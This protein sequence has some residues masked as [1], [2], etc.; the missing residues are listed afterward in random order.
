MADAEK[1]NISRLDFNINDAINSLD[2]VDK[3]LKSIAESSN[4]YAEKI[5]KN[6][7]SGITVNINSN[8]LQKNLSKVENLSKNTQEQ[9]LK[10]AQKNQYKITEITLAEEEKRKTAAYKSALAQEQYN[11]RVAKSTESLYDKITQYAKTYVIYQGFNALKQGISETIDEMVEVEQQMVAIDRV[12][13]EDSLNIDKYRDKLIQLAYDYGNSFNNVADITLRLA[14]AGFDSQE[15][16]ALTEKTLLALNT[17]ELDATQ[18]TDDMVAVMAQWGLMTGDAKEEAESY[19]SIID[20]IN[21]VADN[22][23]TTSADMMDALKK[24]SSAFNLAGASIDETIALIVAAEKTSQRGGKVIGT[25]LSNIVQQIK[26]EGKLDLAE[27]LGLN[28]YT[29]ASKTEFKNIIDIFKEMAERMQSLKDAGKES[30]V[31]MQNLLELFTVFRRNIGASLLGQMSGEDNT[32]LQALETSINSVGYSLQEN[33]KYMRTAKAAQEQFNAELLRLKTQVWEGGLEQTFRDMLS[34]GTDLIKGIGDII[35]KFGILPTTIGTVVAAYTV[36]NNKI[37]VQDIISLTKKITAIN[38]AIKETGTAL[39]SDNKLLEGTS[40]SF[41][42]Y[43]T[44]VDNGKVSLA[45]YGKEL[46]LNTAKTAALTAG[47]IALNAAISFGLSAAITA[48]ISLIDNWIHAQEKA[49]QKNNELKQEA[50]DTA[51]KINQEITSVQELTKEYNE[52]SNKIKNSKDENKLIDVENV[53]KAY[54]LQAKINEAIKDSGKQV[55][56]V[57]ETTNEYGEKVQQ[58]NTKYEE[59]LNLLKTIAFEKKKEEARELKAA[60]ELAKQNVVG[61]NT[62]GKTIGWTDSYSSQLSRAG[63]DKSFGG[64]N[65]PYTSSGFTGEGRSV[66]KDYF[67]FLNTLSPEKQ[68]KTLKEWSQQLDEAASKGE[69]VGDVS[70]YVKEKLDELQSQYDEVSKATQNYSNSLSELY[71]MSGQVDSFNTFLDSI[72]SSY[73]LEGPQKLIQDLQNINQEFSEGQINIQ[74][75]FN[76]IQE[77]ISEIDLTKEGEELEAYQAIFAATTESLAEGIS[78]LNAGLESGTINFADYSSGIKEA[79]ENMLQLRAE[80]ENLQLVDGVWQNASGQV[81]EY[82]NSLQNAINELSNMGDLL[83]TLAENYDYIAENANMAGEAMFKQSQVGTEAYTN[84]AN[85]VASSLNKMKNDNNAAYNAITAKV[86]ESMGK[87]ANEVTNADTYITET[88]N[89]NA[90]ALNAA[91]NEAANQVSISTNRVTV[92]MGN[93]LTQLGNAI[94]NFKYDIKATPYITGGFGLQKDENGLPTGIKLPTFGFDITGTGGDSIQ[95][96][97]TSLSTFGSDLSSLGTNQFRYSQLKSVA[98]PYTPSGS[99]YSGGGGTSSSGT[100]GGGSGGSSR[101][102]SSDNTKAEEDAYKIRL[103]NFKDYISEQERLEKRWV[104]KQK[105]LGLLSNEDYLYITQQRL[106]RYKKYL[107]EVKNATW[108]NEE[109]KLALEKEYS[110]KIEDLQLDYLQYLKNKETEDINKLKQNSKEK[111]QAIKDEASER[112]DALKKVDNENDRIRKKEEYEKK[113]QEHLNDISYWEQRTGRE[114]QEALKEAKKNL[115]ELDEEWQEQLEDW[116]IDDQIKA[117]E[118]ERDAQIKATE[119]AQEA[120]IKGIEKV[121]DEKVKKFAETGE[122]IYEGSTIQ[123]KK[124]YNQ[125]KTNFIDP[126]TNDLKK[127]NTAETKTTTSATKSQPQSQKEEQQYETYLIKR[128]DTLSA[129]ARRYGTTV[130]KIMAANPYIK[131]RNLIYTGNTLQIPKFHEGG[132]VGGNVEGFA[133]LK[134]KEV[135]LKPEWAEGINKLAQMARTKD[136]PITNN[137]TVV[138]VKGNLVHLDAK[139][140]NRTDADYVVKKVEKVLKDKFNI[141]K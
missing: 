120:E 36:L 88:L 50:E 19:A 111:I 70:K 28:F 99:P 43:V 116:S 136:N 125:Y 108:M 38:S 22:F 84:L 44:S 46:V 113:R 103:K 45:G 131:N 25:A 73:N 7:S 100:G 64:E 55:N 85:S 105:E 80:Q 91:L 2:L 76:K 90:Q 97:G 23:P 18:A 78:T 1:K 128:G 95:N 29:D 68:L 33:E 93:V 127:L 110:E 138:E 75:Y 86:F 49:V 82:A 51:S 112:I 126:I 31:E 96:L 102:S 6:I 129:I 122:I 9:M 42:K 130:D 89:G 13:N 135:V 10:N 62:A 3:K 8:E 39:N 67:E 14:Q 27:Q 63:I 123:S 132:I 60:M 66:Q 87:S 48:I 65:Q 47:T 59:Q 61:V 5:S 26:A 109:D 104:D 69:N 16:I 20:K 54:E 11:E 140:D 12:M 35:N 119:A 58:V 34:M 56:L 118:A 37:K 121:Y 115:Q 98:K 30:S 137:S 57:K 117:I 107:E 77:K 32:Y 133:L 17:A 94:S 114:A 72:A 106:E 71:A 74:E 41:K 139:I 81:D 24:V 21:K 40:A 15:S 124:L 52:F 101:N 92:S 4:K 141:K 53:N 134:P 79:A 83:N